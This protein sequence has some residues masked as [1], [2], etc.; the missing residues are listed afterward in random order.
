MQ[1]NI[2][3]DDHSRLEKLLFYYSSADKHLSNSIKEML[4]RFA[5]SSF[6]RR[7]S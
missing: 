2:K 5:P 6:E 3:K 7:P 1:H 4:N